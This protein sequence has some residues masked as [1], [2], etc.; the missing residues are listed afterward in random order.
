MGGGGTLV[1][2]FRRLFHRRTA[3]GS[4]QS[5]NAGEEAASSDLDVA[6]D[7]DLVALGSFRMRLP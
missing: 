6:D 3:S 4:N 5:S 2:G 1:D 7:P